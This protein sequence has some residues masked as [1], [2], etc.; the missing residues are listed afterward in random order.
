MELTYYGQL[1]FRSQQVSVVNSNF[2]SH[3]VAVPFHFIRYF[4]VYINPYAKQQNTVSIKTTMM[5]TVH[6]FPTLLSW[7]KNKKQALSSKEQ[8]LQNS[9]KMSPRSN[10]TFASEE[11]PVVAPVNVWAQF[12]ANVFSS[13]LS[14][15]L[16]T[17]LPVSLCYHTWDSGCK[18]KLPERSTARRL[19]SDTWH[20]SMIAVASL[21]C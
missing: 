5:E 20:S 16:H 17:Q 4:Q 10:K 3:Q 9:F 14:H 12:E 19:G 2:M 1:G 21:Q 15:W 7:E 6:A 18:W 8:N 13:L 11:S